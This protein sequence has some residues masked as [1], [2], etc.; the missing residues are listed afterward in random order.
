MKYVSLILIVFSLGFTWHLAHLEDPISIKVHRELQVA[1]TE[2]IQAAVTQQLPNAKEFHFSRLFT[3]T[4]NPDTVQTFFGY[5][6]KE[7]GEGEEQTERN[8]EGT[9]TLIRDRDDRTKWVLEDI[10]VDQAAIEFHEGT[11]IKAGEETA[12]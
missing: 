2:V 6:F 9:A 11:V 5:T 4:I 3:Q 7:A 1:V 12:L 8:I 10:K